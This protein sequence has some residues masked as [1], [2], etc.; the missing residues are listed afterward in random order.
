MLGKETPVKILLFRGVYKLDVLKDFPK[1]TR[2]QL[3]QILYLMELQ[4]CSFI[5]KETPSQMFS[6]EF[7]GIFRTPVLK[8]SSR[9]L[10]L[11][12][13]ILKVDK[14]ASKYCNGDIKVIPVC[15]FMSTL[16]MVLQS[17]KT[18]KTTIQKNLPKSQKFARKISVAEFSKF[19]K[20]PEM[21]LLFNSRSLVLLESKNIGKRNYSIWLQDP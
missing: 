6:C 10:L 11:A 4:A 15:D 13:Q 3:Y 12:L 1:F 5:A 17:E 18:L 2:R 20:L 8:K 7:G 19:E 9:R 16:K 21:H 14:N